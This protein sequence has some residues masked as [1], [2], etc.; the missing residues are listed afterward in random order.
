MRIALLHYT[1]QPVPGGVERIVEEHAT[2]C[3]T[4]A[5][6]DDPLWRGGDRANN[7]ERGERPTASHPGTPGR[8]LL[9]L[10]ERWAPGAAS[11]D[12]SAQDV[13]ILHNVLTM[14]FHPELTA[15]LWSFADLRAGTAPRATTFPRLIAWIHDIAASNPDYSIPAVA[16]PPWALL[17]RAHPQIEYVAV[18]ESR[19]REFC[20]L[21]GL[22]STNCRVIPNGFNP[23]ERLRLS[24]PIHGLAEKWHILDRH[25]TLLHPARLL[26]R[27]NIEWSLRLTAT[28]R[29][30]PAESHR[31]ERL[32]DAPLDIL[33]L[34][35]AAPDPHQPSLSNMDARFGRSA[36]S[37]SSATCLLRDSIE[38]PPSRKPPEP[39]VLASQDIDSLYSLADALLFPSRQEGFGLPILEAA[40]HRVPI[41]CTDVE[42]MRSLLHS[43]RPPLESG[44]ALASNV[45]PAFPGPTTF[46]LDTAPAVVAREILR[47]I[48][49]SSPIQARKAAVRQYGWPSMYRN[50]LAPLLSE[51]ESLPRTGQPA[52][53]N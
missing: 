10:H 33:L 31:G 37:S 30:L 19:R 3:R 21:T 50:Y 26:R 15:A 4:R 20:D 22:A 38:P 52:I 27:K 9:S 16:G 46:H 45:S 13:V 43:P 51:T 11:A 36:R 40:L 7:R 53:R 42:P 25:V 47:Q 17:R 32:T 41:F 48:D 49:S 6:C 35:T 24:P 44:R 2:L 39:P 1:C 18:S 14:P 12:F 28:L 23:Y 34:L 5:R 29:D 8:L